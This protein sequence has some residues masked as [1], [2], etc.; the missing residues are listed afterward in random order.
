[1]LKRLPLL[2]VLVLLTACGPSPALADWL[3]APG[4][5]LYRE[6]FADPASG[7]PQGATPDGVLG[8]DGGGY[9]IL[10]QVPAHSL[11]ATPGLDLDD[12]HIEV[13]AGKLGGP[14]INRIGLVCRYTDEDHYYFFIISSDGFYAIGKMQ[15]DRLALIGQAE[16]H[17]SEHIRTGAAVNHLRADCVG[18]RLSFYVNGV[19]VAFGQDADYPRGD[20]GLL[21]GSFDDPGVD[22]IFDDLVI[23][24]P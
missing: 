1:M 14:D 11:W 24:K 20:I 6:D 22:V 19:A 12:V 10:L 13:D 17:F 3:A 15:P 18:D 16:M 9:R 2:V 8:Y 4:D 7:W 5:V 23:Y 21:A